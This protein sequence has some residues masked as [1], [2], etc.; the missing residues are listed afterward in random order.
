MSFLVIEIFLFSSIIGL[1]LIDIEVYDDLVGNAYSTPGQYLKLKTDDSPETKPSFLAIASPPSSKT[2]SFLIKE[3][4]NNV[5][6]TS[7]QPGSTGL[8]SYTLYLLK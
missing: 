6:L 7:I 5:A 8:R 3:N 2:F 4:E 1:R